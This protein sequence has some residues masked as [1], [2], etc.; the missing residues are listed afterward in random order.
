MAG[1]AEGRLRR[2]HDRIVRKPPPPCYAASRYAWS[3]S[4][5]S[6]RSAG[7]D[8]EK[9]QQMRASHALAVSL[10]REPSRTVARPSIGGLRRTSSRRGP[11]AAAAPTV[12]TRPVTVRR[13]AL[14][15][16]RRRPRP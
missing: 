16:I 3:P 14:T 7:E 1:G 15:R 2:S 12:A 10:R 6:L 9:R 4:P 8:E 5:A 13:F 11:Y